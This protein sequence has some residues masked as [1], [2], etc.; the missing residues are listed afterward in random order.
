MSGFEKW[1]HT[2]QNEIL[3]AWDNKALYGVHDVAEDVWK[4]AFKEGY[5]LGRAS[6]IG[7]NQSGRVCAIDEDD[8]IVEPCALHS[9][10]KNGGMKCPFCK[11]E[12]Y[13]SIAKEK[14]RFYCENCGKELTREEII[15][16]ED[17]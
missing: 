15:D 6:R 9:D 16:G 14:D 11:D 4:A 10:W 13:L 2:Y 17:K 1:W 8:R 7:L 3:L 12:I 5:E